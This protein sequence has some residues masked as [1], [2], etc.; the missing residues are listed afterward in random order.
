MKNNYLRDEKRNLL[1]FYFTIN[2]CT[3]RIFALKANSKKPVHTEYCLVHK[4][5]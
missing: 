1:F 5:F 2:S 3:K 4:S